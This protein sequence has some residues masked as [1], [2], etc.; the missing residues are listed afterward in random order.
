[1]Q[2][3][4]CINASD[5]NDHQEAKTYSKRHK[6]TKN[7]LIWQKMIDWTPAVYYYYYYYYNK[8]VCNP[9]DLQET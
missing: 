2:N 6:M 5:Q 3:I 1:M 7:N 9:K 8:K 4:V